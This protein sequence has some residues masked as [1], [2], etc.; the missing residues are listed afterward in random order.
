MP[1][2]LVPRSVVLVIA[3]VLAGSMAPSQT[4]QFRATVELATVDFRAM[5]GGRPVTDLK[6]DEVVFKIDG[7]ARALQQLVFAGTEDVATSG[8]AS[9][10]RLPPPFWTNRTR[11]AGRAFFLYFDDQN[12]G[13]GNEGLARDAALR[14]LD[15]LGVYDRVAVI[16]SAGTQAEL[17]TDRARVRTALGAVTSHSRTPITQGGRPLAG[18]DGFLSSIVPIEGPKNVVLISEGVRS[19][20]INKTPPDVQEYRDLSRTAFRARAQIYLIRPVSIGKSDLESDVFFDQLADVVIAA[21]GEVFAPSGQ[22]DVVFSRIERESAGS[23]TLGFL[24]TNDES[25]GKPHRVEIAVRRQG[26]AVIARSEFFFAKRSS[27]AVK[28]VTAMTMLQEVSSRRELELRGAV[29][30]AAPAEKTGV[31]VLIVFETTGGATLREAGLAVFDPRTGKA[32]S[33]W[34][35]TPKEIVDARVTSGVLLAPGSYRARASGISSTGLPGSLEFDFTAP[36]AAS[37]AAATSDL[38]IGQNR[39]DGSFDPRVG[40]GSESR[41]TGFLIFTG[42]AGA[43]PSLTATFDVARTPEGPALVSAAGRIANGDTPTLWTA[44]GTVPV[45]ALPPGD[46]LLRCRVTR[47]EKTVVDGIRAF[48]R[49]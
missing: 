41:A 35:L 28:P 30:I 46:Y 25:D 40:V 9:T 3:S 43:G 16:T 14:F 42:E 39:P 5:S 6:P 18:L 12:I 26:V 7:R 13:P 27:G 48:R 20:P 15:Q 22:A 1:Y 19:N 2:A 24:P 33:I 34:P 10:T 49:D 4:P 44:R 38:M 8:P 37:A 47:N 21:G 23:Y 17:T 31:K 29:Y 32:H 36:G 45:D 11:D